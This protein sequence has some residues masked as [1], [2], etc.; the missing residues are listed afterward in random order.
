MNEYSQ[1]YP[2]KKVNDS[3]IDLTAAAGLPKKICDYLIDAPMGEY[4]PADNN[5][6]ARCRLWK[7]LFYD[8]SNPLQQPLPSLTEKMSVLFNPEK[9][10]DPPTDKGYRLIP[11]VYIDPSQ[12]IAQTR[13]MFTT[14]R[15]IPSD[16]QFKMCMSIVF[17]IW[18]N[19]QYELNTKANDLS[20]TQ[21]IELSLIEALNGVNMA[22]IGTFFF[23]RRK[24]P[25]CGSSVLYDENTN[26]GRRLT[27][28][29]EF[30]TTA[31]QGFS[32]NIIPDT[33]GNKVFF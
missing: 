21:A 31:T 10:E 13:I 4:S 25:D 1:W 24:H 30:A 16:D 27:I 2:Y 17:Y 19:Q 14:G 18:T 11:Q 22:G 32:N 8:E 15:T 28:A 29:L 3:Y 5:A 20:R 7:Y 6:Y 12:E 33:T 9:P 23:S 26:V